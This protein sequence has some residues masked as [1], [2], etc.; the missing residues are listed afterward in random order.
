LSEYGNKDN[1]AGNNK[2]LNAIFEILKNEKVC[3]LG[4]TCCGKST[5]GTNTWS[6]R[7]G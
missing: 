7:Y 1:V 5:A 3:I 4:T 2:A 6:C